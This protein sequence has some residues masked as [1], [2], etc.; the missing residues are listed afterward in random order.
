[1]PDLAREGNEDWDSENEHHPDRG[2]IK[3]WDMLCTIL[4]N[5]KQF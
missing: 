4:I 1:M 5:Y 2:K 3:Y